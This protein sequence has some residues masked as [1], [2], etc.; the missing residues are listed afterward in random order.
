M[1]TRCHI[2]IKG[3]RPMIYRHSDGYPGKADG[4]ESSPCF[5]SGGVMTQ[6]T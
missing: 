1:S 4:S 2:I 3:S 5:R 6:N